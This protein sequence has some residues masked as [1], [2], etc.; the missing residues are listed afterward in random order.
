[1]DKEPTLEWKN[2]KFLKSYHFSILNIFYCTTLEPHF[3]FV[4]KLIFVKFVMLIYVF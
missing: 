1:M 2:G 3:T 4:L